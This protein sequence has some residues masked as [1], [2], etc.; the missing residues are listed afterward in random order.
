M[1]DTEIMARL[2]ENFALV[3]EKISITDGKVNA[4]C[5]IGM[6]KVKHTSV[7]VQFDT[8]H[9]YFACGNTNLITLEGCPRRVDYWFACGENLRLESLKGGPITVGDMYYCNGNPSLTSLDGLPQITDRFT[10]TQYPSLPM[11]RLP[12]IKLNSSGI[13]LE[14]LDGELRMEMY[15]INALKKHQSIK[16]IIWY[17]QNFLIDH[18]HESNAAW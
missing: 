14:T 2:R 6:F 10:I 18:G 8:V 12:T 4:M 7:P 1:T 13:S 15:N 3:P 11:L 17:F 9:G 16:Q 5:D